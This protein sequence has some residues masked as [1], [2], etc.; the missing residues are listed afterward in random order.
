MDE[1]GYIRSIHRHLP[2]EVYRWKIN[3]RFSNGVAD[4]WYSGASSDLW[5]EYKYLKRTPLRRFTVPL[6]P[7]QLRWLRRRAAEGRNVRIV[8]GCPAGSKVLTPDECAETV[9]VEGTWMPTKE[10]AQW[11]ATITTSPISN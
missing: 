11:I 4:A 2:E 9:Q 10:V 8:V 5:V 6:T 7:M 1:H 3:D